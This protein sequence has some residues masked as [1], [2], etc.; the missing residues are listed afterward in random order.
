MIESSA[1]TVG[2]SALASRRPAPPTAACGV[3]LASTVKSLRPS[4]VVGAPVQLIVVD[5]SSSSTSQP[6]IVVQ[7][8]WVLVEVTVA[9][10]EVVGT[11]MVV[12]EQMSAVL[13]VH[14]LG[15][16]VGYVTMLL[17]PILSFDDRSVIRLSRNKGVG[18]NWSTHV[19]R[20]HG[21]GS[22]PL[23]SMP[24]GHLMF[25]GGPGGRIPG[26][27]SHLQPPIL[28]LPQLIQICRSMLVYCDDPNESRSCPVL[29][30][31]SL[32]DLGERRR[33]K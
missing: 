30:D 32:T 8:D 31:N 33:D 16:L 28:M 9:P 1:S 20:G 23:I 3:A 21:P 15:S 2:Q 24:D 5:P 13:V 11:R 26:G 19:M 12:V 27:K 10:A 17:D 4:V 18:Q 14:W 7:V 25:G 29:N 22:L 6:I